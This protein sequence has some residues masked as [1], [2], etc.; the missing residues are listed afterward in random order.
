MTED[1]TARPRP[2][3]ESRIAAM[4]DGLAGR[5]DTMNLILSLGLD[6]AWRRA[7][8]RAAATSPGDVVLD[9]G[10]GTGDL[11]VALVRQG[12]RAV[13]LDA[14]AGMLSAA[15]ARGMRGVDLVRGSAFR[16]PFR[17]AAFGGVASAFVLRNLDD[18]PAAFAELARVTHPSGRLALIDITEPPWRALRIGFDAYFRVAAP[19]LGALSGHF[20]EYR[21]LVRSVAHLPPVTDLCADLRR[22]G[23]AHVRARPLTGGVVTLFTGDRAEGDDADG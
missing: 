16:L 23:F 18:L 11:S 17:D 15:V 10:C 2:P 1:R 8:S 22:A 12:V 6:R 20:G 7:A 13:G 3:D 4:F 19:A 9:L 21:Y 14:S 5:Y